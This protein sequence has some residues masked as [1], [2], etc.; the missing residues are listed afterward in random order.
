MSRMR[1][2]VI[3]L[4]TLSALVGIIPAIAS[5]QSITGDRRFPIF[6]STDAITVTASPPATNRDSQRARIRLDRAKRHRAWLRSLRRWRHQVWLRHLA[7][8]PGAAAGSWTG[9]ID[10]YAIAQCESGGRW[11]LLTGN[12]YYGGLQFSQATWVAAGGLQYAPR[13]DLATAAEQIAVASHL[14]LSNWPVCGRY[15]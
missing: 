2:S 7:T 15:G 10:W 4:A 8:G 11:S 14:S 9:G 3:G 13:A 12:G 1:K 5:A 6:T